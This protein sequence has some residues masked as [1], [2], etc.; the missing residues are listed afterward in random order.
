[1][2][3]C[4]PECSKC[5]PL[6]NEI[7]KER[8]NKRIYIRFNKRK[9]L[10]LQIH[11]SVN[12]RLLFFIPYRA[13]TWPREPSFFFLAMGDFPLILDKRAG[14]AAVSFA[15]VIGDGAL[16]LVLFADA[17]ALQQ[18]KDPCDSLVAGQGSLGGEYIQATGANP[19]KAMQCGLQDL[20]SFK[21]EFGEVLTRC[22]VRE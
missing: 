12:H 4:K 9:Y 21:F 8:I 2:K 5:S 16:E 3:I 1:M 18:C 19:L 13:I 11:A 17:R 14:S 15:A 7:R 6:E 22:L 10:S 20:K